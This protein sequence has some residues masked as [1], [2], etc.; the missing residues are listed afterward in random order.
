MPLAK[1]L[2]H[3]GLVVSGAKTDLKDPGPAGGPP[4][5]SVLSCISR[6]RELH[7]NETIALHPLEDGKP[8]LVDGSE[9]IEGPMNGV[10]NT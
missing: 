1:A 7:T 4:P 2:L 6:S 5:Q 8:K 3:N 9:E 10:V